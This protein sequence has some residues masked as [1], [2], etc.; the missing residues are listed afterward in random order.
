VDALQRYLTEDAVGVA[1]KMAVLRGGERRTLTVIPTE[2][3]T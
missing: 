2:L 1:T 3:R